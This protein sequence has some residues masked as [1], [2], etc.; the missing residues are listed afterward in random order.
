MRIMRFVEKTII[1]FL[2]FLTK[3]IDSKLRLRSECSIFEVLFFLIIIRVN[4]HF[5]SEDTRM[6]HFDTSL[7]GFLFFIWHLSCMYQNIG[8][9]RNL[10]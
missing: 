9:V 1:V 8:I 7:E 3:K 4:I 6:S 5:S 2:F 10:Y